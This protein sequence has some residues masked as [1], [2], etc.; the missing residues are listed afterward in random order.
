MIKE[1]K[2][3]KYLLNQFVLNNARNQI[4]IIHW[5]YF[6]KRVMEF[7]SKL[8]FS[9]TIKIDFS[10]FFWI[11]STGI[12]FPKFS[13][14]FSTGLK[15]LESFFST[16]TEENLEFFVWTVIFNHLL[17]AKFKKKV[18]IRTKWTIDHGNERFSNL[19]FFFYLITY[20]SFYRKIRAQSIPHL[21]SLMFFLRQLRQLSKLT[22]IIL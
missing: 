1:R 19:T 16:S 5:V 9:F 4:I 13:L 8:S 22:I 12:K 21:R 3:F 17:F 10:G 18:K 11:I 7:F 20:Q 15:W 6:L 14:L 2:I